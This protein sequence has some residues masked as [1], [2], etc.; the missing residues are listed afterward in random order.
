MIRETLI[1]DHLRTPAFLALLE[2]LIRA[3]SEVDSDTQLELIGAA[4]WPDLGR[5]TSIDLAILSDK[6]VSNLL[7]SLKERLSTQIAVEIDADYFQVPLSNP[8][9]P[10]I[11]HILR[12]PSAIATTLRERNQ[13]LCS[14]KLRAKY[15]IAKTHSESCSQQEYRNLKEFFWRSLKSVGPSWMPAKSPILKVLRSEEWEQLLKQEVTTGAPIDVQDG[16]I[17]FSTEAQVA[18][19]VSKHFKGE[20]GLWLLTLDAENLGPSLKWEVS[21]GGALFPHLYAPLSLRDV[22]LARPWH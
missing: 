5:H 15:L 11:L 16:Y 13:L 14:P 17:H 1:P 22:C 12:A 2:R 21:R 10:L 7:E 19:T 20:S 4:C 9:A 3:I 6:P 8:D 18:E